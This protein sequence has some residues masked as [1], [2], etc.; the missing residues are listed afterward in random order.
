[1]N[2]LFNTHAPITLFHKETGHQIVQSLFE[3]I[4]T[5]KTNEHLST[6]TLTELKYLFFKRFGE[7]EAEKR[8]H[9]IL[10]SDFNIISVT[11][12]IALSAGS[13]KK[14]GISIKDANIALTAREIGTIGVTGDEHFSHMGIKVIK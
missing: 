6:I 1:M 2:Y 11:I 13:I 3:E 14:A 12:S 9:P 7:D 5:G 8:L 10:T 4:E